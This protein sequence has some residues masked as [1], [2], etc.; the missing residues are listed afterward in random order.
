MKFHIAGMKEPDYVMMIMTT[1][2]TLGEFGD[3][4]R[5]Y[6]VNGVKHVTTFRHPEVVHNHYHY[7][8]VIDN[9]S[10]YRMHPPSMEETWMTMHWPNRVYV[11]YWQSPW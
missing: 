9:L 8:D 11:S 5:H 2:S 4:E 6:M 7:R 10:S 3:E 1:Y